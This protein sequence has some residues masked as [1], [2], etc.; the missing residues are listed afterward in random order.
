[1]DA[2]NTP[3]DR[4]RMIAAIDGRRAVSTCAEGTAKHADVYGLP[5]SSQLLL[6]A[7]VSASPS[8]YSV[9]GSSIT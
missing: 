8:H 4:M 3:Y 7:L 5:S 9:L 6:R 2:D 1:M